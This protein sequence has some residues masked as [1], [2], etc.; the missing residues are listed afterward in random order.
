MG[1]MILKGSPNQA[2]GLSRR[3][4]VRGMGAVATLAM[5]GSLPA[6]RPQAE[7]GEKKSWV[8][9]N[10]YG[11][12]Q[13]YKNQG[14]DINDHVGEVFSLAHDAGYDY[15]EVNLDTVQP[16]M[17][18]V[19]AELMKEK[20]LQPVTLYTGARLHDDKAGQ[21]VKRILAI[22]KICQEAG[23]FLLSCNPDP[24]GR[25]KTDVELANQAAAVKDL[26]QGLAAIGMKLGLHQHLPEMADNAREFHHLFRNTDP[27]SVG[28]C[29]DVNWV[30]RGGIPPLDALK[31]Y[32]ERVVSWHLRQSRKG[33]W[34]EILDTGDIDYTAVAKF[35]RGHN[36]PKV[37]TVELAIEP[38]M[39]ITRDV[40][41]NHKL[42]REFVKKTFGV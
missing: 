27:K 32:G 5:A 25:A 24:I 19:V 22:A 33:V 2:A 26:G 12:G 36:L 34:H 20:G 17:N 1:G 39:P 18:L 14:K 11:W 6:F 38:G 21:A 37:Y 16:A 9:T 41:A 40:V 3:N 23:F 42:S 8:G 4:F 28:W 13:Y 10:I 35:A 31:A 15:V 29:Y 7:A 30:F